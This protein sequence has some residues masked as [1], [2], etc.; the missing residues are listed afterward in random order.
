MH[1]VHSYKLLPQN[2][3][4]ATAASVADDAASAWS[5]QRR[6]VEPAQ[7]CRA[8]LVVGV[9]RVPVPGMATVVA[10][11]SAVADTAAA[12]AKPWSIQSH[13]SQLLH[14]A[15]QPE[16]GQ[17]QFGE[18]PWQAAVQKLTTP[19]LAPS[20]EV[21]ARSKDA[22]ACRCNYAAT[23]WNMQLPSTIPQHGDA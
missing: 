18:Q 8:W 4:D 20:G 14:P 9:S 2:M 5:V 10:K 1:A 23:V 11:P 16:T 21:V 6:P 17:L 22:T 13:Q 7:L 15:M 19:V 3:A 12:A